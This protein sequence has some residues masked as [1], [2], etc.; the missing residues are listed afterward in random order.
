MPWFEAFATLKM[1]HCCYIRLDGCKEG[2]NESRTERKKRKR[3][4]IPCVSFLLF[5]LPPFLPYLKTLISSV[6]FPAEQW[7]QTTAAWSAAKWETICQPTILTLL[8]SNF[9][10]GLHPHSVPKKTARQ[11]WLLQSFYQIPHPV[12]ILLPEWRVDQ[13][14]PQSQWW[15]WQLRVNTQSVMACVPSLPH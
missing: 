15:K 6:T 3:K 12:S 11:A 2:R 8:L 1:P 7:P 14:R 10:F 9:S 4:Y 5:S 13:E